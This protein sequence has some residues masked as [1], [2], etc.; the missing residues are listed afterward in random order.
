MTAFDKK[1]AEI[2]KGIT[3]TVH[4]LAAQYGVQGNPEVK[5]NFRRG[6][7]SNYSLPLQA[8]DLIPARQ[9]AK[10]NRAR[11]RVVADAV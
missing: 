1:L 4:L 10:Y 3:I 9:W 2:S 6:A 5:I 7:A 11:R 8:K